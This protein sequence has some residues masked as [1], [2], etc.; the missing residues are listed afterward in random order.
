MIKAFLRWRRRRRIKRLERL[1]DYYFHQQHE[2]A[3]KAYDLDMMNEPLQWG[4]LQ[5]QANWAGYHYRL[6]LGKLAAARELEKLT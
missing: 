4:R 3:A 6:Y 2:W 5:N 1:V